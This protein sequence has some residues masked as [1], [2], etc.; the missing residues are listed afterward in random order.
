MSTTI[1]HSSC[2]NTT[3]ARITISGRVLVQNGNPASGLTVTA[4]ERGLRGGNVLASGQSEIIRS[5][6]TSPR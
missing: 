4:R 1:V 2:D 3:P 5:P 6:S